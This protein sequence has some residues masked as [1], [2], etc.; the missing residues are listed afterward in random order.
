MNEAKLGL[1]ITHKKWLKQHPDDKIVTKM[2][3]GDVIVYVN[4]QTAYNADD[5]SFG[6]EEK[7][8]SALDRA[9]SSKT[10]GKK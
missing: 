3:N 2:K 6:S 10:K 5:I 9:K 7:I 1:S 4:G 8:F